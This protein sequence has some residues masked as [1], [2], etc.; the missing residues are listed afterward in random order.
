MNPILQSNI[1][2]LKRNQH[3]HRN[4]DYSYWNECW[5]TIFIFDRMWIWPRFDYILLLGWVF[6][7]DD[8]YFNHVLIE[9]SKIHDMLFLDRYWIF[10]HIFDREI[11]TFLRANSLILLISTIS[12]RMKL[13]WWRMLNNRSNQYQY[14]ILKSCYDP[15]GHPSE[16]TVI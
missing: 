5:W 11:I 16:V 13:R 7:N 9:I 3:M 15:Y 1:L 14:C 6:E 10:H 12:S 8:R 4:I 2:M